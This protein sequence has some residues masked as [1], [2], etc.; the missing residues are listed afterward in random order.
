METRRADAGRKVKAS[1]PGWR[2]PQ[3]V[4]GGPPHIPPKQRDGLGTSEDRRRLDDGRHRDPDGNV[5]PWGQ[6]T[7]RCILQ[8]PCYGRQGRRI[9]CAGLPR[10]LDRLGRA[11]VRRVV[12]TFRSRN[13]WR[14]P[15][16]LSPRSS[17]KRCSPSV[18]ARFR[19]NKER[20]LRSTRE[21]EQVLLRGGYVKCG[22]CGHTMFVHR[23]RERVSY[24]CIRRQRFKDCPGA[25]HVAVPLDARGVVEGRGAIG[26]ILR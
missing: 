13:G 7:I 18:Q 23:N 14:S 11:V 12:R 15:R 20:A 19:L 26:S 4:L 24:R 21:P 6:S 22:Y 3:H 25:T 9:P 17:R 1:K 8:N 10:I 16:A 2:R 5:I